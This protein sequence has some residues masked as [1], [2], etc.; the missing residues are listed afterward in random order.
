MKKKQARIL[1]VVAG[2]GLLVWYYMTHK[3]VDTTTTTITD[4]AGSGTNAGGSSTTTQPAPVYSGG[5]ST[6]VTQAVADKAKQDAMQSYYNTVYSLPSS[7]F[8]PIQKAMYTM[9][10]NGMYDELQASAM[11]ITNFLDKGLSLTRSGT[12]IALYDAI[13]AIHIKYGIF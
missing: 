13:V 6:S 4:T 10:Q 11:Y 9:K 1:L 2:G 3:G 5:L 7:I 12:D 8:A